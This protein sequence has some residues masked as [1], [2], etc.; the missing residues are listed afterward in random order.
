MSAQRSVQ[1]RLDEL[2]AKLDK[3]RYNILMMSFY[4]D[5][6][7]IESTIHR[8]K[9]HGIKV[10]ESLTDAL[11]EFKKMLYGDKDIFKI[12]KKYLELS[13]KYFTLRKEIYGEDELIPEELSKEK[14][15]EM[16]K[17]YV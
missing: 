9:L 14:L 11:N 15:E 6:K 13:E 7:I 17:S 2:E 3:V 1:K 5:L 8:C 12:G 10:D 16:L 4:T